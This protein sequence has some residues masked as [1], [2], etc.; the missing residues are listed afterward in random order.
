MPNR[1]MTV[2]DPN[3]PDTYLEY[4]RADGTKVKVPKVKPKTIK[5]KASKDGYTESQI[6]PKQVTVLGDASV[7]AEAV[8]VAIP[9]V[10]YFVLHDP[11]GDGSYSYID[12]SMTINTNLRE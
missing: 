5:F 3:N 9:N 6:Y 4:E 1:N 8:P 2:V 10:N 11:P 12:D 7:G